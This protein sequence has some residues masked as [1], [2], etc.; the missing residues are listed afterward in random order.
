[1]LGYERPWSDKVFALQLHV[2]LLKSNVTEQGVCSKLVG[3]LAFVWSAL[4]CCCFLAIVHFFLHLLVPE[5]DL[6]SKCTHLKPPSFPTSRRQSDK[7]LLPFESAQM[8]RVTDRR[9]DW[10]C[11]NRWH[12]FKHLSIWMIRQIMFKECVLIKRSGSFFPVVVNSRK[13]RNWVW[14]FEIFG[15]FKG[16]AARR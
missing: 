8:T 10:L 16:S 7:K 3:F 5:M 15:H 9:S 1:M 6:K 12:N 2:H 4:T 13:E 11:V 14:H